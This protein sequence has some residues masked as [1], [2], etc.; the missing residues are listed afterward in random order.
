MH[1]YDA[2]FRTWPSHFSAQ[3]TVHTS[4]I[5][6][7]GTDANVSIAFEGTKD[8]GVR[9]TSDWHKLETSANNF[10]RGQVDE[11]IVACADVGE[12][13]G[14]KVCLGEVA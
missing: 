11:F 13:T 10:E 14:V 8:K 6:G 3:V 1:T 2:M 7:A 5:K 9:T 4:D 12:L